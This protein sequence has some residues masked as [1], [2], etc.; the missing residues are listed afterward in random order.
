MFGFKRQQSKSEAINFD[1]LKAGDNLILNTENSEY[2]FKVTS[3]SDRRGILSGGQ[4]GSEAHE[5]VLYGLTSETESINEKAISVNAKAIFFL[6]TR[7]G[8]QRL[9]TSIIT[10]L[11]LVRNNYENYESKLFTHAQQ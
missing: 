3:P 7:R 10:N 4:L 8:L 1:Q 5:A 9:L 2:R 11:K 6:Q